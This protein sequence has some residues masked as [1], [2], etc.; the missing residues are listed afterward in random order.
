MPAQAREDGRISIIKVA[1]RLHYISA[2]RW[3][4]RPLVPYY[5]SL[6]VFLNEMHF[7]GS[8]AGDPERKGNNN[9]G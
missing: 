4:K 7:S 2:T 6:R 5:S 3:R 8:L 1:W 9:S